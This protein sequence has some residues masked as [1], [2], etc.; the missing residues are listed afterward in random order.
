MAEIAAEGFVYGFAPVAMARTRARML[1]RTGVN[2]LIH[3]AQ[4]ATPARR[5]VVSP[6]VD[7][8]YT[9]GWLDL[10]HGPALLS[11]PDAPDRYRVLQ[12]LDISAQHVR[13]P[14]RRPRQLRD[15]PARLVRE[16]APGRGTDRISQLGRVGA[17]AHPGVRGG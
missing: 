14:W 8:L 5:A 17:R 2:R 10:R 15:R 16:P 7:T 6:N 4:L 9:L 13:Q 3:Q 12:L 1:P 11:V